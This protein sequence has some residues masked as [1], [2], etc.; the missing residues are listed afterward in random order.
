[1]ELKNFFAQDLEGNFIP[2]PTV[3]LY[4][5]GTTTHVSGLQDKDGLALAN[6]FAGSATGQILFAAPDGDYDL[7]V[8]GAGRDF[9]MRVRFIDSVAAS[10][11]ILRSDLDDVTGAEIVGADDDASGSLFTTVA[12]FIA[13]VMSSAG[14]AL[15]GYI[16]SGVGAVARTVQSKFRDSVSVKDFG[17]VGDGVT[18]DTAAIQAA[19]DSLDTYMTVEFPDG[20]YGVSGKLKQHKTG[21]RISGSGKYSA[22]IVPLST[23]NRAVDDAL[24]EIGTTGTHSHVVSNLACLATY[25]SRGND[26]SGLALNAD[27]NVDVEN[28]WLQSGNQVTRE[29]GGLLIRRGKHTTILRSHMH[30][31]YA[32]GALINS[33][34]VGLRFIANDFDETP[35]AIKSTGNIVEMV[36]TG[37]NKFG[38]CAPNVTYPTT[39]SNR[40]IDLRT[41]AHGRITVAGNAFSGGASNTDFSVDYTQVDYAQINTNT[42]TDIR[43]Y[44]ICDRG[45]RQL[46]AV[47]NTF[48]GCGSA[49]STDNAALGTNNPDTTTFCADIFK[50]SCYLKPSVITGNTTNKTARPMAWL[51]G[52][53]SSP[54]TSAATIVGNSAPGGAAYIHGATV[55]DARPFFSGKRQIEALQPVT[56][57]IPSQTYTAGQTQYGNFTYTGLEATDL[58][59]A[60][61]GIDLPAG[62]IFNVRIVGAGIGRWIVTNQTGTSQTP[63]A[64]TAVAMATKF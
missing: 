30:N 46:T 21:V 62:M 50:A 35:V 33:H 39:S 8:T 22:R 47:G 43:R 63:P 6:P 45:G 48:I 28:C 1:M 27:Y 60:T 19:F 5:P 7:R 52:S 20:E 2:T 32:Y 29:S 64:V 10:A 34:N 4:E 54:S 3:H 59:H 17:A 49:G 14:S 24:L 44:A 15:M 40:H 38:Q 9:T 25:G 26:L 53:G 23:F 18:D 57:T 12:G 56:F 58:L 61:A 31:G 16:H 51:E 11:A 55:T 13:R 41:G 42:F 37:D 36:V